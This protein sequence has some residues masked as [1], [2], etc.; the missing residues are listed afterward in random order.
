[1][2]DVARQIKNI[3]NAADQM[4]NRIIVADISYAEIYSI[5]DTL[6]VEVIA[7]LIL[8]ERIH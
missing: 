4:V 8:N 6:N 5:S 1:M 2:T 3:I 7:A